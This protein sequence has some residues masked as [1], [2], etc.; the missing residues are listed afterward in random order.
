MVWLSSL[1]P[2][3]SK[4]FRGQFIDGEGHFDIVVSL[5][6]EQSVIAKIRFFDIKKDSFEW[7]MQNST[8][9]GKTWFESEH[10][11]AKRVH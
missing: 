3:H 4:S 2:I 5:T 8:D 11:T 6:P 7:S 1:R 9:G 10:I